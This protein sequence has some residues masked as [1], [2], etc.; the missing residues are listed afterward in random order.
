MCANSNCKAQYNFVLGMLGAS[1]YLKAHVQ[2]EETLNML[3]SKCNA[4]AEPEVPFS[5]L[6]CAS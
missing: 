6:K 3:Q 1:H 2:D 5:Q 4:K